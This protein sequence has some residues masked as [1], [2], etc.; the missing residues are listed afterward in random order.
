MPNAKVPQIGE[1]ICI[2][3]AGSLNELLA[4]TDFGIASNTVFGRVDGFIVKDSR[5]T[6]I[7][8]SNI[9]PEDIFDNLTINPTISISLDDIE[10]NKGEVIKNIAENIKYQLGVD[11]DFNAFLNVIGNHL[12]QWCDENGFVVGE[13]DNLFSVVP[14]IEVSGNSITVCVDITVKAPLKKDGVDYGAISVI[15]KAKINST[16]DA[17]GYAKLTLG[18]LRFD[19]SLTAKTDTHMKIDIDFSYHD[20]AAGA[21]DYVGNTNT[22]V[23]H[24]GNCR[25]VSV[26]KNPLKYSSYS[27][28]EGYRPC[29]ICKPHENPNTSD[30]INA[31]LD[32]LLEEGAE[33]TYWPKVKDQIDDLAEHSAFK[34]ALLSLRDAP[35]AAF[36]CKFKKSDRFIRK[37]K[38]YELGE[39]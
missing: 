23:V 2:S 10:T 3:K 11:E 24:C 6:V 12:S 17:D 32:E 9:A 13:G 30:R 8:L 25:Y 35:S 34:K 16:F 19:A 38:T 36:I 21:L 26:I 1:I 14:N 39:A 33:Y 27:N 37:A 22:K 4:C 28:F 20:E 29:S 31:E 5:I 18:G 7:L 15:I